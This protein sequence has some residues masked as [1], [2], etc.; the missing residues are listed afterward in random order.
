MVSEDYIVL[1]VDCCLKNKRSRSRPKDLLPPLD[2][3]SEECDDKREGCVGVVEVG[4]VVDAKPFAA[5]EMAASHESGLVE[6]IGQ[7]VVPQVGKEPVA[8]VVDCCSKHWEL[9]AYVR[10]PR[11]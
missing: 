8:Q 9:V 7:G 5:R 1:T 6:Y 11:R 2:S 4:L 10:A 3:L